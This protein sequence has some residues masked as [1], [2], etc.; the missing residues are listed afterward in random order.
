MAK[1]RYRED[2]D[3]WLIN[4]VDNQGKRHQVK[5]GRVK[6][7]A[8]EMLNKI[9][10]DLHKEKI[11]GPSKVE[12]KLF[13]EFVKEYKQ[14][15]EKNKKKSTY[16]ADKY[17]CEVLSGHFGAKQLSQVSVKDV[18]LYKDQLSIT[19]AHG[20]VNRMMALLKGMFTKA[21]EWGYARENPV[22]KVKLFKLNNARIRYL[23]PTEHKNLLMHCDK[24]IKPFVTLAIHTGMRKSELYDLTWNDVDLEKN[25]IHVKESKN[26]EGRFI[27]ID[28]TAKTVLEDLSKVRHINSQDI[29]YDLVNFRRLWEAALMKAS[30]TNFHFHDCRHTFAS[31]AVMSGMD[32][33]TLQDI[34]GHKTMTMT[35]RYSH[36]SQPHKMTAM[37]NMDNYLNKQN[38]SQEKKAQ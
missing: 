17:T 21:I 15:A 35:L 24:S 5:A 4:Y 36:L 9:L 6:A 18:Q 20:T 26:G 31:Y 38:E 10:S 3:I 11:E 37:Q 2:R 13:S 27:P 19:K 12:D 22:K 16:D 7:E 28:A 1:L 14:Y 30:I 32:L 25:T 33:R 29:F 34:M 23:N 8:Q